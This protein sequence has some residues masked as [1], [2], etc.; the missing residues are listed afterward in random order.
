MKYC[1]YCNNTTDNKDNFCKKCGSKINFVDNQCNNEKNTKVYMIL[2]I[3]FTLIYIG[4]YVFGCWIYNCLSYLG[5]GLSG[6]GSSLSP[7]GEFA[8]MCAFSIFL[9][10]IPCFIANIFSF[11]SKK[12][13]LFLFNLIFF[14]INA[15]FF[16]FEGLFK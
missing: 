8:C 1:V 3:V 16:F 12:K 7:L 4:I 10:F 15:F 11:I 9:S 5:D 2:A 6:G 13:G 14:L